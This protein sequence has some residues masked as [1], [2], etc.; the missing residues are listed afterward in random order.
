MKIADDLTYFTDFNASL[1]IFRD[2]YASNRPPPQSKFLNKQ[3]ACYTR[4]I[5]E[6]SGNCKLDINDKAQ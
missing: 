1:L 5:V 2:R 6:V 3:D 4:I